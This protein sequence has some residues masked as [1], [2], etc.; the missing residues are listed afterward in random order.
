MWVC[1]PRD[2]GEY[3]PRIL[4][5]G[6]WTVRVMHE[7][8]Y[9]HYAAPDMC[10]VEWFLTAPEWTSGATQRFLAITFFSFA[11]Y[12]LSFALRFFVHK[13]YYQM[14]SPCT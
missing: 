9:D 5:R 12:H 10:G 13:L 7:P 14:Y 4:P 6:T 2:V 11:K 8:V 3:G 1:N